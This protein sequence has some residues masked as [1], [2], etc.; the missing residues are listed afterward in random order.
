MLANHERSTC[1]ENKR[2]RHRAPL[3]ENKPRVVQPYQ[4]VVVDPFGDLSGLDAAAAACL[5]DRVDL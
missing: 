1:E 2:T 3:S 5:V 4:H